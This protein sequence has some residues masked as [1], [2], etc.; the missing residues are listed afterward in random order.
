VDRLIPVVLL[1]LGFAASGCSHDL[2]I[3]NLDD[4]YGAP[5]AALRNKKA[6]RVTMAQP[7]NLFAGRYV[8]AIANSL[9]RSGNFSRVIF[10]YNEASH[11]DQVDMVIAIDVKPQYS[12]STAN[13]F[14]NFPGFLIFAPAIWGY[15]YH[16]NIATDVTVTDLASGSASRRVI[17]TNYTFRQAEID[18]TWTEIGWFE[19]G[20]TPFIGGFFFMDYDPD[21]TSEFITRVSP[22]YGFYVAQNIITLI[23]DRPA[24][25]APAPPPNVAPVPENP[26][27]QMQEP[28]PAEPQTPAADQEKNDP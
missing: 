9:Q 21:V 8:N 15:E 4:Y 7:G 2:R 19:W 27:Q 6:A 24:A 17:P 22:N 10:P 16:A 14:I 18:R 26:K 1:F 5:A 11:R 12:G 28:L 25:T 23:P 3:T 20:I 13:F